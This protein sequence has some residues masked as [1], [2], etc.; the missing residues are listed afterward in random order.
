VIDGARYGDGQVRL[1]RTQRQH[2]FLLPSSRND[3]A[4][5][6]EELFGRWVPALLVYGSWAATRPL[7]DL[8]YGGTA[9]DPVTF[10]EVAALLTLIALAACWFP[11]RR[12]SRVDPITVLRE[13]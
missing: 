11:A 8:L 12:A 4:P 10:A 3:P 13:E 2:H 5:P 9:T 1:N 6:G 7:R